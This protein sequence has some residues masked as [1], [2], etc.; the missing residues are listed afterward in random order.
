[1]QGTNSMGTEMES[2]TA[3]DMREVADATRHTMDDMRNDVR[4]M[5]GKAGQKMR[6]LMDS[7]TSEVCNATG[8]VK[9]QIEEKPIQYSV[10]ALGIGFLIGLL[11][12]R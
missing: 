4:N 8:T 11:V 2:N 3:K 1:M 12:R 6:Q 7:A 9:K 10:A 5:A